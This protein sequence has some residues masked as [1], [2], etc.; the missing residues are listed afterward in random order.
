VHNF[1]LFGVKFKLPSVGPRTK[2]INVLLKGNVISVFSDP[3]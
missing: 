2:T 3:T 1:A